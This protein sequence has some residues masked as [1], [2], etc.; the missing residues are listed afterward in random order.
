MPPA[1]AAA[2][3]AAPL[4]ALEGAGAVYGLPSAS[5]LIFS[6]KYCSQHKIV[7]S[8][9]LR[10]QLPDLARAARGIRGLAPC[11]ACPPPAP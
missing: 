8:P 6:R 1:A 9:D 11:M 2:G 5:A 7:S 4:V 10:C 3:R